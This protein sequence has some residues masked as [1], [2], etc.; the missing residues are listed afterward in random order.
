M[1]AKTIIDSDAFLDMAVTSQLL[2]F[3]LSM[4]ADDDGFVNKPK[5]IM[6]MCNC[7]E[8][9]L[10]ILAENKF[11]I[12]FK[13]GIVVIKHWQIHNYLRKDTYTETKYKEEKS[14]LERDE[15]GAYRLISDN[16]VTKPSRV[17]DEVVTGTSTQV[18]KGK[19][20]K[21]KVSIEE[22]ATAPETDKNLSEAVKAYESNIGTISAKASD[23]ISEWLE[24]GADISLIIFAIEQ[25]AEYN[26]RNWKY[27]DKV[28]ANHYN[29]GRKTRETAETYG[30]KKT[31]NTKTTSVKGAY[32][33]D[34]MAAAER[35]A[36]L[37]RMK[38]G[39]DK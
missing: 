25:A 8:T 29:A 17:R 4:R 33:L 20:R 31:P 34:D 9:D 1:F 2:Y 38:K 30:K 12:P 14:E 35:K 28:I 5:S 10:Q 7:K 6:R 19:E 32:E 11:I 21:V 13:S 23:G 39:D 36:R 24:K 27:A 22:A 37:E 26:A 16:S 18:R 3:H 15:N